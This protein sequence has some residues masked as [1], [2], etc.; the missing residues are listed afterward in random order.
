M[1]GPKYWGLPRSPSTVVVELVLESVRP[2]DFK[3]RNL[4][5]CIVFGFLDPV[6]H[7]TFNRYF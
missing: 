7:L 6:F 3:A 4:S 1:N 2:P 5:P